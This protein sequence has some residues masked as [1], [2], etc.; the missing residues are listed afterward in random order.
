MTEA[1][2]GPTVIP[3]PAPETKK[4]DFLRGFVMFVVLLSAVVVFVRFNGPSVEY[5]LGSIAV[6][7]RGV[8]LHIPGIVVILVLPIVPV[9][10]LYKKIKKF[11]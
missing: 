5:P 3:E 4:W 7:F 2:R 11:M 8:Y 9:Y 10:F 1:E 6:G